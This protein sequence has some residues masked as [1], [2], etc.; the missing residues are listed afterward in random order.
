M[1]NFLV[2]CYQVNR[3]VFLARLAIKLLTRVVRMKCFLTIKIPFV[4][5]CTS[6]CFSIYVQTFVLASII[7]GINVGHD[8]I[9]DL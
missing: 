9:A 7:D 8:V 2:S 6:F 4:I 3:R 5:I 1:F